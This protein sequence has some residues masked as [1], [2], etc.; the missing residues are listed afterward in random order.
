MNDFTPPITTPGDQT[1]SNTIRGMTDDAQ[2]EIARLREQV[3]TLMADRVNPTI[4]ALASRA[5]GAAHAATGA[6]R[7]KAD[8][9]SDA[10]KAQPLAAVGIAALAGFLI[11]GLVRR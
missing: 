3:E 7:E 9:F 8:D 4:A 11:A 5:E 6:M 1:M 2:A 10:V